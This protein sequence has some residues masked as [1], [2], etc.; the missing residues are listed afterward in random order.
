MILK[1]VVL[2]RIENFEQGGA[3]VAAKVCAEL[4]D[5]VEQQH[6]IHGSRFLHHLNDLAGQSANV[7]AAMT[8]NLSFVTH[9]AQ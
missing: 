2:F 9:A 4:V 8:A 5:F 3:W 6:R 7:R 1:H